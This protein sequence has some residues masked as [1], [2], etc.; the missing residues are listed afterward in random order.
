MLLKTNVSLA[1]CPSAITY[2]Q[3]AMSYTGAR[4]RLY[5]AYRRTMLVMRV[6]V[7]KQRAERGVTWSAA[8]LWVAVGAGTSLLTASSGAK[9]LDAGGRDGLRMKRPL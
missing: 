7:P 5:A 6:Q 8:P 4:W 3:M 2:V 1:K 9:V